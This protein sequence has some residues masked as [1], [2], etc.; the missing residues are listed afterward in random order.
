MYTNNQNAIIIKIENDADN[1]ATRYFW[2]SSVKSTESRAETR[3]FRWHCQRSCTFPWMFSCVHCA[4]ECMCAR[5]QCDSFVSARCCVLNGRIIIVKRRRSCKNNVHWTTKQFTETHCNSPSPMCIPLKQPS[6]TKRCCS[7][8]TN[9]HD[10]SVDP[11]KSKHNALSIFGAHTYKCS[12]RI[13]L[14]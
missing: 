14:V 8:N 10:Q 3:S 7:C 9:T 4:H 1:V 12:P 11:S 13:T 2:H 5:M 6:H